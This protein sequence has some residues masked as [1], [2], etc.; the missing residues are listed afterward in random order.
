MLKNINLAATL[1]ALTQM[2]KYLL[3]MLLPLLFA[4]DKESFNNHNPNIENY[5][6]SAELNTNLPLYNDLKYAGNGVYVSGYGA[7]GLWV[8]YTGSGYNAFDA[9][10]PNQPISACSTLTRTGGTL[11]CPCD[12]VQYSL[13]TGQPQGV[14]MEY[15][16]KQYRVE[17]NGDIVRVYN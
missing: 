8:F 12:D 6:F 10:C 5:S 11:I 4:C 16:L 15:P 17:V 2:K 13:F 7:R 9:A 3:L 1:F 14:E